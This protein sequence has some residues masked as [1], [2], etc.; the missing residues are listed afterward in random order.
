MVVDKGERPRHGDIVIAET[1]DE[2][3][4][5]RLLLSPRLAL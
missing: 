4:V 3:T 2:F 1:D 5:K